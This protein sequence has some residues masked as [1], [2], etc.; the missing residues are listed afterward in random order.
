MTEPKNEPTKDEQVLQHI[1][2][3]CDQ[4]DTTIKVYKVTKEKFHDNFVLQN[5]ISMPLLQI[6]E[7]TKKLSPGFR[8]NNNEIP[9]KAWAGIRDRFAHNYDNM[10]K[11]VIWD[12]AL[13]D[14]PK[15]NDYC[16]AILTENAIP[17][18]DKEELSE[19]IK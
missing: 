9:W 1:I 10:D 3:Y 6:G 19:I 13:N 12:T 5:A 7:L 2:R 16:K 8:E 11:D 4:I 17:L 15:L 18:P 14:I